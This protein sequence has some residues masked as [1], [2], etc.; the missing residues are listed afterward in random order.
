M[1]LLDV[2]AQR[3]GGTREAYRFIFDGNAIVDTA[4]PDDLE[5]EDDDVI[6]VMIERAGD[7]GV[8][9]QHGNSP[10]IEL[11]AGNNPTA[12]VD[13]KAVAKLVRQLH[14]RPNSAPQVLFRPA[15]LSATARQQLIQR[16]DQAHAKMSGTTSAQEATTDLKLEPS[17]AEL[18]AMIGKAA[19]ASLAAQGAAA[20]AGQQPHRQRPIRLSCEGRRRSRRQRHNAL[21]FTPTTRSGRCR[22][23]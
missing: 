3:L 13:A 7:I 21:G 19:V 18:E 8:F 17:R 23:R 6:D 1:K 2:Y 10:G 15:L 12:E 22:C 14:A 9:G 11:L 20:D 4:T 5:M 16:L